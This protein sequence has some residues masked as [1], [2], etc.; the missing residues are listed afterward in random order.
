VA[1]GELI[2]QPLRQLAEPMLDMS[3]TM[4][5]SAIQQLFDED[6]PSGRR[7]YW[8]SC[9]L[10]EL[11]DE[12]VDVYLDAGKARPSPLSS[13]DLWVLGGAI[14]D[15]G[16]T[17]SP[18]AHRAAPFLIGIESNWEDPAQDAANI[19]WARQS[20]QAFRPYSDGSYLNFDDPGESGRL[21]AIYGPNLPRLVEVKQRYDPDNLF[22]SALLKKE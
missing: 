5:F 8:R 22:R 20:Q 13:L 9:Y 4:P 11:H 18:I 12:V 17:E 19:G 14:G 7:Y 3:G 15:V 1:D 10:R 16:M 2:M 21:A 6:Y